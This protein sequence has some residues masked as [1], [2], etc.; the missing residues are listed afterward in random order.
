[1]KYNIPYGSSVMEVVAPVSSPAEVKALTVNL[2]DPSEKPFTSQFLAPGSDRLA[3]QKTMQWR[4]MR[5][6]EEEGGENWFNKIKKIFYK[7]V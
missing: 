4:K 6:V 2:Q 3:V 1:M 5:D 7:I